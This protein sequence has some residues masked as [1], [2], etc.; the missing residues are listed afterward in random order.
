MESVM[1]LAEPFYQIVISLKENIDMD[2]DMVQGVM[3][4]RKVERVTRASGRKA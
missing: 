2:C 1:A 4:S 3:Y